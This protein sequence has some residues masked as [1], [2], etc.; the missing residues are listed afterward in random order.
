MIRYLG[1]LEHPMAKA[2]MSSVK[3]EIQLF[4]KYLLVIIQLGIIAK[5]NSRKII[6]ILARYVICILWSPPRIGAIAT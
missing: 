5:G 4:Y 3:K 6:N 2:L 1:S